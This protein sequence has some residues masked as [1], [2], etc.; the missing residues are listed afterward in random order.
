MSPKDALT[1]YN[2][3]YVPRITYLLPFTRVLVSRIKII[4][5]LSL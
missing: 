2:I 1:V 5:S 4:L 3:I